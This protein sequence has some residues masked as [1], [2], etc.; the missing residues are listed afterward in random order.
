MGITK[1]KVDYKYQHKLN[2]AKEFE[3]RGKYLHAIQ[4][5]YSLIEEFPDYAE[6]YI[7]LADI[8][9][10]RGKKVSAEEVLKLILDR[11]PEN[12]EIMLYFAQF[13]MQSK[14]WDR[15]SE[16]LSNLSSEDPFV[17]YLTGYCHYKQG[18]FE[19]ARV[20]LLR[21]IISD[22]EPE[23]IHEAYLLLARIEYELK[24]FENALK[25]AK[26]AE[27]MYDDHWELY[28]IFTKIYYHLKMYTHA[29]DAILKGIKLDANE[30]VLFE[31]AGKIN[32]KM[33]NF[34]KAR[35]YFKKHIDLKDQ[36]TSGDYTYLA[37]ACLRSGNLDDALNYYDTAI[38][39]DPQNQ[40]AL[41]GKEKT[42]NLLNNRLASDV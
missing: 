5:Y 39:L 14:E 24:Q 28:L 40:L 34:V 7:N 25:Y 8:F 17:S 21:F 31:W 3:A 13:L 32:L 6:S 9:L 26:K 11:Q 18:D 41:K 12:H 4:I 35:K 42:N 16:M 20:F 33:D 36:I 37:E 27:V 10:L 2:T 29:S 22:E 23:L 19:L 30:A 38:K 1:V 15:A